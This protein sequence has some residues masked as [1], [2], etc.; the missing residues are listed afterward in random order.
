MDDFLYFQFL[1]TYLDYIFDKIKEINNSIYI[2]YYS[3][4]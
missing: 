1:D 4:S 2:L 3:Y